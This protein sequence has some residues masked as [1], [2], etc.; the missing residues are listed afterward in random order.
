[1]HQETPVQRAFQATAD[2]FRALGLSQTA[3]SRGLG[4]RGHTSFSFWK[5]GHKEFEGRYAAA[6]YR[7]VAEEVHAYCSRRPDDREFVIKKLMAVIEAWE[8]ACVVW[9]TEANAAWQ[10][11]QQAANRKQQFGDPHAPTSAQ[12]LQQIGQELGQL[13]ESLQ[14]IGEFE[15]A[16]QHEYTEI[17]AAL[18]NARQQ[19]EAAKAAQA[20]PRGAGRSRQ[21]SQ[22]RTRT[23]AHV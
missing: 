15:E 9:R 19:H 14:R 10:Q 20:P 18:K 4:L 11:L 8:D 21:P 1:M 12:E 13:S 3:A 7:I 23:G 5:Q 16:W 2:L 17:M 22:R 6:L